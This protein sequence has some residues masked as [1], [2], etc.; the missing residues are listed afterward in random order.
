MKAKLI[1]GLAAGFFE[2]GDKQA[3]DGLMNQKDELM[4]EFKRELPHLYRALVTERDNYMAG[5]ISQ[6][7]FCRILVVVGAAHV[8]G[9]K[10]RLIT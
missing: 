5:A 8:N 7:P 10:K 2:M 4:L 9:I 6:L 1:W 3:L